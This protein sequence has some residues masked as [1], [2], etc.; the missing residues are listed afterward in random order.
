MKI[1]SRIYNKL[2]LNKKFE[3]ERKRTFEQFMVKFG[4]DIEEYYRIADEIYRDSKFN[5][6]VN[7]SFSESGLNSFFPFDK[8][9]WPYFIYFLIRSI[10]P[11]K[12]VETGVWYGVSSSIIL[13][14]LDRNGKG[15]LH[16]IDLPAYFETG[17][18]T[19]ENPYLDESKRTSSLPRG[20]NPGFIVPEYLKGKWNLILGDSK[21]HLQKLF[22]EI[23]NADI[24]LHDSLHSYDNMIFEFETALKFVNTGGFILSDNIDWHTAFKD[25]TDKHNLFSETF[26]AY[27]ESRKLKHNFGAIRV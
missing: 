25:F 3:K 20:K 21:I 27:Y 19:D 1:I 12:I 26:L 22:E 11:E 4:F 6:S 17:G 18:Y 2:Y 9:S 8:I 24:F 10:K 7:K 14:A 16:S 15:M 13:N 23:K 5:E